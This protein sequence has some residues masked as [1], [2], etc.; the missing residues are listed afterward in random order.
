MGS[1]YNRF[2]KFAFMLLK[3]TCLNSTSRFKLTSTVLNTLFTPELCPAQCTDLKTDY[4][5]TP[6]S[7]QLTIFKQSSIKGCELFV[8]GDVFFDKPFFGQKP[9]T[10]QHGDFKIRIRFKTFR[11]L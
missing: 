1:M 8:R 6:M 10:D 9:Y 11:A 5:A 2:G 7:S 3:Q 4:I